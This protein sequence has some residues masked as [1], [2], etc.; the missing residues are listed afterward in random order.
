MEDQDLR[1][2]WANSLRDSIYKTRAKWTGGVAHMVE[3]LLCKYEALSLN[4]SPLRKK[5]YNFIL[6]FQS[7]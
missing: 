5:I 3:H 2:A 7:Q 6:K 4:P 1:P